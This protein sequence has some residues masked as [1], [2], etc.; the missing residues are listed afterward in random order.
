[1]HRGG[2]AAALA[3]LRVVAA[4][5]F[6]PSAEEKAKRWATLSLVHRC[7]QTVAMRTKDGF[8][9]VGAAVR[10]RKLPVPRTR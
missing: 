9:T 8:A 2:R 5:V 6:V 7:I 1:M 4:G 3:L 10:R